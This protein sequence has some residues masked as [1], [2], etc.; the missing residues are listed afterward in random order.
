MGEVY[1][2]HDE[3]LERPAAVKILHKGSA[4]D[5]E[6]ISRLTNEA[7]A[8][9]SLNHPNIAHVY[10]AGQEGGIAYLAME[11]VEGQTLDTLV[12]QA[13]LPPKMVAEIA[14]QVADALDEAHRKGI[15]HRDIKPSNLMLNNRGQIKVLDFGVAKLSQRARM[16]STGSGAITLSTGGTTLTDHAV[17]SVPYMSPE[18]AS[19]KEVDGRSDIFSFGAVLYEL[20]TGRR[21]FPGQAPALIF[22]GILN[23]VP[24][25]P[26]T[27]NADISEPLD[28]VIRKCLEKDPGL[29]YQTAA[30]LVADLRLLQRD[31]QAA[32][33][34]AP[35]RALK[36]WVSATTACILLAAGFSLWRL[37]DNRRRENA[38]PVRSVPLTSY[39][40]SEAT[41]SFSPEGNQVAFSWNQG[42]EDDLDI[43]VKV[44]E[45][46]VPL[47]LTNTPASEYSPAWSP[48]G[49]HIAFL[50]QSL[51]SAGFYLIPALGG[52]ERK[53]ADASPHRV[54]ADAPFVAW[55]PD[56]KRLAIVDRA[57]EKAPLSIFLIDADSGQR[58]KLTVPP[59]NTLGD[60]TVSF[61]PD[62]AEIAFVRTFSLAVQDVF[63]LD[64]ASGR[65]RQVTHDRRR[66]YGMAWNHA[67]GKLIISTARESNNRLWR[68]S[69]S[70]GKLE[71]I[72]GIGEQAGYITIS[73][74]GQ[75]LA[76]TRSTVDTNIWR[77][78]LP[79]R[80]V[81]A[82]EGTAIMSS[83]RLEQGPRY[84]P[85]GKRIV[86]SS[87]RSGSYE[88][89]LSDDGGVSAHQL[90][91]MNATATGSPMWSPD[92]KWIAFDSRPR[93]NP[94]VYVIGVERGTPRRLTSEGSEE[95]MPSWS[96]DGKWIYF[97]SNRTGRFE[98]WKMPPQGGSGSQVTRDGGFCGVESPD[99]EWLYYT[100]ASNLP[101]LYRAP[102]A[103]GK[104]EL[105]VPNLP[106]G[107]SS[108]WSF[109]PGG[110]YYVTRQDQPQGGARYP[111]H[112]FDTRARRDTILSYLPK[113]PFN[114]GLSVSPDGAWFLYTQVDTSET[115][116][117]LV[118]NFR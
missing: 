26:R 96:R 62:G 46:G 32:Q 34:Q 76:Y 20:A 94:D 79:R 80:A 14:I 116:I 19:A 15:I 115:D 113:R 85:D 59:E 24:T 97:A 105:I 55:A 5:P 45:A 61:S 6:S 58:R 87:N 28:R 21:A 33:A 49:R 17:G 100:K 39:P 7:R 86:F 11:Y 18:Q 41:P 48:D 103:G 110:I 90:T 35:V 44:V 68:I 92:G 72:T 22:D 91:N 99:G 73:R 54:G 4:D 74:D 52:A 65:T 3:N 40:G 84:S 88:I 77:Y 63:I 37:Y 98:I 25:P 57:A 31:E 10:D 23:R 89:W 2:A 13:P 83:T 70:D 56:S 30:D 109:G 81:N 106:A 27:L 53:I 42:K 114:N 51:D 118:D 75:H 82:P 47:Q 67:D 117:T 78:R 50:R 12:K 1:L 64:I 102:V 38:P 66:I 71:R 107:Y 60:S 111:L 43:F 9:A 8:A 36:W 95:I 93:G 16:R 29:R 69:P 101:G 108:Y 104:E 112:H